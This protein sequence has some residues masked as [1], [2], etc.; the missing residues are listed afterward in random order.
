MKALNVFHGLCIAL[1]T[2]AVVVLYVVYFDNFSE[3]NLINISIGWVFF[4]VM[5][6]MGFILKGSKHRLLL[7][8]VAGLLSLI[9]LFVFFVGIFPML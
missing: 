4:L 7:S 8:F 9:V 2:I 1:S 5:G 6:I 3:E